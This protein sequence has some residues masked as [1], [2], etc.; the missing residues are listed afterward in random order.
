MLLGHSI[1]NI[2]ANN[3]KKIKSKKIKKKEK[4]RREKT[5]GNNFVVRLN[6]FCMISTISYL[7]DL[8]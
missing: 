7:I 4:K 5:P 8:K 2:V 1:E 6:F 3:R